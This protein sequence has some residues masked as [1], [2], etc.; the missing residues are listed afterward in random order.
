MTSADRA[1]AIH[2]IAARGL[3]GASSPL[4]HLS[5]IQRSFG[6]HDVAD[7]QAY[8]GNQAMAASLAIGAQAYTLGSK[9]AFATAPTLHTAA[10]EAAHVVQQRAGVQLKGGVGELGDRYERHA[11]AVA[12]RVVQ[13]RSAESLLSRIA[14][15]AARSAPT[16]AV[17]GD[18]ISRRLTQVAG[19][20]TTALYR[21]WKER[22][23]E[24]RVRDTGWYKR[25]DEEGAWVDGNVEAG[26]DEA[27]AFAA[28]DDLLPAPLTAP[29]TRYD[30]RHLTAD[31]LTQGQQE[32]IE[33]ARSWESELD[34]ALAAKVE[35]HA[36]RLTAPKKVYRWGEYKF[37][38]N[39]VAN[40][41]FALGNVNY[42]P[43]AFGKGMYFAMTPWDSATY[44]KESD[45]ALIEVT[46]PVGT[47]FLDLSQ[48]SATTRERGPQAAERITSEEA[49]KI[50]QNKRFPPVITVPDNE[51]WGVIKDDRL[52]LRIDFYRPNKGE[53][54]KCAPHLIKERTTQGY[55]ALQIINRQQGEPIPLPPKDE[56]LTLFI[57]SPEM[58]RQRVQEY[59]RKLSSF[60]FVPFMISNGRLTFT[61]DVKAALKS[62]KSWTGTHYLDH[63]RV[64]EP[65][66]KMWAADPFAL[67]ADDF[68]AAV[69]RPFRE[70]LQ[71]FSRGR[72]ADLKS[73]HLEKLSQRLSAFD[74]LL[75]DVERLHSDLADDPG[76]THVASKVGRRGGILP[77]DASAQKRQEVIAELMRRGV[78]S[79]T[80]FLRQHK[81]VIMMGLPGAGKSSAVDREVKDQ[82]KYVRIDPDAAKE[83]LPE[84]Q[85]GVKDGDP[86][87][88]TKVHAESKSI[89]R[90]VV[91]EARRHGRNFIYD[92]TGA[93]LPVD[94]IDDLKREHYTVKLVYV[95][96]PLETAKAR[97]ERRAEETKRY[98]PQYVLD[99]A[100]ADLPGALEA[101]APKAHEVVLYDNSGDE[102]ELVWRGPG[103][104]ASDKIAEHKYGKVV[105]E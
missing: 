3:Q 80:K 24:P 59:L 96:A 5:A 58:K 40:N 87:I 70:A 60:E 94:F 49:S 86:G 19:T 34:A 97:V 8:L 91:T 11:D 31:P 105:P 100:A 16:P 73:A 36:T 84:Y 98:V 67:S 46:I 33:A 30:R 41:G 76:D 39:Y 55:V 2:T 82:H 90:A 93:T 57:N 7:V 21:F 77:R 92:T 52:D 103:R 95:H 104:A 81:A 78:P 53:L 79:H 35:Q 48:V 38:K 26:G 47:R 99:I 28:E 64:V 27:A 6:R 18:W 12:D 83:G 74:T 50:V 20:E 85:A 29:T 45:G 15:W 25:V 69:H 37:E 10:H 51:K 17:Q 62:A 89:T 1:A 23:E 43:E 42:G 4:P 101:E 71:A 72:R 68:S 54:K 32:A 14:P 13:G 44:A 9:V 75:R 88:A 63:F 65:T 61:D 102:I 56:L 66:L 22:E